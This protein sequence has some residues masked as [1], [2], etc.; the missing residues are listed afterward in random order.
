[1]PRIDFRKDGI[2]FTQIDNSLLNNP[3]LSAKA[4]GIYCYLYSKP[5]GWQF[6]TDRIARDF[7]DGVKSIN[8]GLQELET[9]GYLQRERLSNGRVEYILKSPMSQT[10]MGVPEPH[11]PNGIRPKRHS[12]QTDMVSNT[13]SNSNKDS[14]SNTKVGD[15]SP[16]TAPEKEKP[17]K[18]SPEDMRLAKLLADLIKNNYPDWELKGN[19]ETWAEHVEKLHRIDGKEYSKIEYTIRWCQNDS[20]W[21]KNILSTSKLREKYNNLIPHM[22]EDYLKTIGVQRR[23]SKPKMA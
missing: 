19:I 20:F 7:A 10:D 22:K 17:P 4:K 18:Y 15:V 8:S 14:N 5:E 2:P 3:K 21:R 9:E 12:A 13:D 11:V 16:T 23:A 1:M 6:A